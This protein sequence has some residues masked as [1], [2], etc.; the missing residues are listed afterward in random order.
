MGTK[1]YDNALDLITFSRASGG[2]ALRKISYG[3]ELVTNGTF[4]SD[5]SG[6]TDAAAPYTT[7]NWDA[8]T[9]EITASGGTARANQGPITTVVG[10]TYIISVT[11]TQKTSDASSFVHIGTSAG[12]TQYKNN[13][14]K[15]EAAGVVT[16]YT[17]T[18][19]STDLYIQIGSAVDTAT[20]NFDNI[21]VREINPLSVSIQMDGRMTYADTGSGSE[22]E[23]LNWEADSNN[24]IDLYLSAA[25]TATGRLVY[26]QKNAGTS[27][28]VET[29][30]DTL[31][32]D[33]LVPFNIA[34]RHGS[35]FINGAVDGVALTADTTPVALPDLSA[36]D[37]Q[38]GYDFMGTIKLF[39]MWSDDLADA[40]IAEATLPSLEPSLSLTFDGTEG[41]FTVSDWSA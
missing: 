26:R 12:G 7:I 17:F 10:Q 37:L 2:T 23:F 28:V 35:T 33:I 20:V 40:G 14:T 27:D 39:R 3:S 5:T 21:S 13:L 1:V 30:G 41:S 6:W 32:P 31:S 29:G 38:L 11:C 19:T 34:S 4:D 16:N 8:G 36:T 18:A 15:N 22:V 24:L 9:I 25:S